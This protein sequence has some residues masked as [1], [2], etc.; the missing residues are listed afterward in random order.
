MSNSPYDSETIMSASVIAAFA[1]NPVDELGSDGW[2]YLAAYWRDIGRDTPAKAWWHLPFNHPAI[3][4]ALRIDR[5]QPGATYAL[6]PFRYLKDGDRHLILAAYPC[7]HVFAPID[8]DWL[9][10]ETVLSWEPATGKVEVLTDKRP[11]LFGQLTEDD[12]TV[13]ADPRAFFTAWMRARAWYASARQQAFNA[14]WHAVPPERD[15]LPG[16]LI[17]GDPDAIH[18]PTV[19]MP[20]HL[21]CVGIDPKRVNRAILKSAS[22]PMC[23]GFD[24]ARAA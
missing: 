7:P 16:A 11:Q 19:T 6:A 20:R 15:T 17:V 4:R 8:H 3:G 23:I 18:W 14:R 24:T 9:G 12:N 21:Q 22:L 5:T 10:I 1:E 13:F 2:N